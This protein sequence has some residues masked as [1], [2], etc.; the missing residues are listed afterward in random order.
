MI[1]AQERLWFGENNA[2]RIGMFDTR[3]E[4]FQEW[5][6]PT[7]GAWPYD[8]TADKNGDV[9]SGG[10]YADRILR[11]DPKS[12]EFVEYL[13]P[14]S[15][16]VRRVFVDNR[17]TPVTFWVGNN[18]GASIVKLEPFDAGAQ[19][20]T[21]TATATVFEGA[22][23]IAGD[24]R[25][26]IEDGAFVVE[27]GRVTQVGR[28]GAV[29]SPAGAARVDLT[30]KTVMP[31]LVDAHVHLGYRRASTF[32]A[33]NYTRENLLD[34]LD[35]FS[36]Y[37]VAAVLEAGTGRGSLPFQV[38]GETHTGARYLTAGRGFAMPNAGPG[39]PMRDAAYGVTTED[40][41][42]RDVRELAVNRPDLIK[43]WV[44]DRNG[45]VEKLK[46]NLYRAIIDEAHKHGI[47][48]MAH[49]NALDDAKDLLRAGIDGFAHVVRDKDVDQELM[50]L[51]RQHP[52][53]FF[54]ETL[55]GERNAIYGARP[56]WLGDRLL[57]GPFTDAESSSLAD[58]VT[59]SGSRDSAERLLRNV[60]TLNRAGVRLGLGT[61]TGGVSG[62]GY[63]GLGSL[64]ELE[65]MVKAGLTPSQAIA[66]G[67]RTSAAILGL[68]TLGAIAPGKSASFIVLDRNPLEDIASTRQISAVYLDGRA[69]D[70]DALLA[71]WSGAKATSRQ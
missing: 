46:P 22:R 47:R 71:K 13:L 6:V 58:G 38:R 29:R 61:D 21:G 41:A 17:T 30:G 1:D 9:W 55:W 33:D 20:S 57:L 43:I 51:L 25:A 16:N 64:I 42:R 39:V 62:G 11:L 63:F 3:T 14:R 15:T 32:T 10:E 66:A 48:V 49:I 26:P 2:D 65:L 44:D 45:T 23:V 52:N 27:N 7:P 4:R 60:A 69:V 50:A 8:V 70:R 12:G 19:T 34:E 36:Y 28:K 68:D 56:G 53:V 5:A 24:G 54:V 31:A 67:T 37:G 59:T 18:H 35:R 40:E